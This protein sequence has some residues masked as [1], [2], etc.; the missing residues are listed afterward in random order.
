MLRLHEWG[1]FVYIYQDIHNT[2]TPVEGLFKHFTLPL[3]ISGD[4]RRWWERHI[5]SWYGVIALEEWKSRHRHDSVRK[6]QRLFCE[7]HC[8]HTHRNCKNLMRNMAFNVRN[9]ITNV[10]KNTP[11]ITS[12]IFHISFVYVFKQ[13]LLWF[14]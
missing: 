2:F 3:K 11:N 6:V 9:V 14:L 12:G 5:I 8:G 10:R 1:I 13:D 4:F 7:R